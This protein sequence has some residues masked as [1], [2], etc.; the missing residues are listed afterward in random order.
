MER[1]AML[2]AAFIIVRYYQE[3]ATQLAATHGI[4]YPRQL[5]QVMV[6]RL[7]NLRPEHLR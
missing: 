7:K 2:Q 6:R 1:D 4:P 5:E 3:V